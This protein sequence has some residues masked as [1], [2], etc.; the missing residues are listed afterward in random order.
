MR[1]TQT[2]YT[3][4]TCTQMRYHVKDRFTSADSQRMRCRACGYRY[5]PM[6]KPAGLCIS[7]VLIPA[8]LAVVLVASALVLT[9]YQRRSTPGAASARNEVLSR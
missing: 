1:Y 2:M 3:C 9:V 4:P 7:L 8:V 6:P 5:T